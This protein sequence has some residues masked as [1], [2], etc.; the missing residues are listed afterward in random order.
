MSPQGS[1][2]DPRKET[3][4][5]NLEPLASTHKSNTM[6]LY[7]TNDVLTYGSSAQRNMGYESD[8]GRFYIGLVHIH[9]ALVGQ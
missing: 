2:N 4:L 1:A 6:R 7:P 9:C 3:D 5:R 8:F